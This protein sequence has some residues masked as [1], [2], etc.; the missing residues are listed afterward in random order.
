MGR[1]WLQVT[2]GEVQSKVDDAERL[3]ERREKVA[4]AAGETLETVV[5]PA[6]QAAAETAGAEYREEEGGD[7]LY[8]LCLIDCGERGR[9]EAALDAFR[10]LL[11][12]AG[13]GGEREA[14]RLDD[15]ERKWLEGWLKKVVSG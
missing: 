12:L 13:P 4:H 1:S 3:H 2:T 5:R 7:A 8:R 14:L 11:I 6:M 9:V 15:L 10:P